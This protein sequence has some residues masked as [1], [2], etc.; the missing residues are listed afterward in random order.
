MKSWTVVFALSMFV[1]SACTPRS[2]DTQLKLKEGKTLSL[3]YKETLGV[4]IASEPPTLDWHKA[5][6]TT[7]SLITGN[8]MD[9]LVSYD[10]TKKELPLI[11]ALAESWK[12]SNGS[13]TWTFKIR[14]GVKWSD[15]KPFTTQHVFDGWK[16][17]LE[18][19]TA[20]EYAYF[21]F[22][23]RGAGEYNSGKLK[24]FSGV[25][26][27]ILDDRRIQVQ[28]DRPMSYFP[29]LLTHQSTFPIRLDIVKKYGD[30]WTEP[31]NI[32]TLGAFILKVWKHDELLVLERNENY[33]EGA[34]NIRYI[35]A[36]M[37][38]KVSTAV[39]LFDSS[40]LDALHEVPSKELTKMRTRPEF[41]KVGN[42]LLYYYGFNVKK[43]PFDNLS[44]RQAISHAI[45]RK[46]ITELLGGGQTPLTS[47]IPKGLLGYDPKVG[48]GF[49][50][51]KAKSLLA[52]AGFGETGKKMPTLTIG[53]NTN[54]D[55]QRIAENIQAQLQRNLGIKVELRNEEWKVYLDRLK[56]DAY[57]IFRLGWL[58][59]YPD[60][61]NFMNL[62]ASYSDNNHTGW[63]SKAYDKLIESAASEMNS[64]KR[65]ILY[66]RAQ[67]IL[68][69]DEVPVAPLYNGV[70]HHLISKR[71]QNYPINF[72]G[73]YRFKKTVLQ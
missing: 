43:P 26:V 8:I 52:Q 39:R 7:S 38:E 15:G 17:L 37:I 36:R 42:L 21:L 13:R 60:P 29:S 56:S 1:L 11:P 58:A 18:P 67:K 5:T 28:L 34:P 33:F 45:D 69:E 59:D 66:D 48:L 19:A 47:W 64:K 20:S 6:D 49:D 4:R 63:S 44:V 30:S 27:K 22:S 72:L 9:G 10:I 25:G 16:R 14:E 65:Q 32:V 35:L 12:A 46:E 61:D 53:F 50:L 31:G 62:M 71:V 54:E 51:K 68:V 55:H 3:P 2:K 73:Y 23:I 24:D 40:K 57:M 70:A 41:R